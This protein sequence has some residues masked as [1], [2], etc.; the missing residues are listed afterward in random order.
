MRE[1]L[2]KLIA[3]AGIASRRAA[4]KM[5][6][7]GQVTVNG[8]V[9]K[10]L[11]SKADPAEDHI[12]VR[13]K[14]INPKLDQQVATYILLNK[15]KGYLSSVS[16]PEN[17]P[18]VT[19]LVPEKYGRLFPVGRLDFK[20]EG[21]IILTNDGNFAN[22]VSSTRT[23][24]KL[25]EVKVKGIPPESAIDALGKGIT[26]EDGFRTSPCE[27]KP[28]RSAKKNAWF[29]IVLYEGHNQQIRK[30]FDAINFSAVKLRRTGIGR[31]RIGTLA[32][33]A[34]R[35]LSEAEIKELMTFRKRVE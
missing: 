24:P 29:E 10:Q 1:R 26:L 18:L 2:Q 11:G 4:E 20:T 17:R 22:K 16:D 23:I 35:K 9:V 21:L 6:A 32:P 15:P 13:G 27:I 28:L 31:V 14:L 33:G 12:K 30:M 8:K 19:D 34:H 5:I 25:Y 3:R 7:D